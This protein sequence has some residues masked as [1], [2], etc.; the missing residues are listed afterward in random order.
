MYRALLISPEGEW[1][2]GPRRRFEYL[3]TVQW[4][5]KSLP[6]GWVGCT[7][8]ETHDQLILLEDTCRFFDAGINRIVQAR[9]PSNLHPYLEVEAWE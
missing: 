6:H 9:L 2:L 3:A 5:Y 7:V 8:Q 1:W 4:Y